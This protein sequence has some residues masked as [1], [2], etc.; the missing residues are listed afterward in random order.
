MNKVTPIILSGGIGSRLWPLSTKSK[1]KQFLKLP[2]NSKYNIFEQTLFGLKNP[3][4]FNKPLIICSEEHK[5]LILESLGKFKIPYSEIIVE[6]I[7]K[8]TATSVLLGVLYSMKKI[9]SETSLILPSDHFIPNRNYSKLIPKNLK[10]NK[11]HIIFGIKPEFPSTDYGYISIKNQKQRIS[12]V[13][14]FYEKPSKKRARD[15]IDKGFFWN[16]GIFL[17]NNETILSEFQKYIPNMFALC[18]QIVSKLKKDLDFLET[19][20]IKMK[21]LPNLSFDKAI[22]EKNNSLTMVKFCQP[23]R[24]LGSWNTLTEL[25]D[26][27]VKLDRKVKI[28]NNSKNSNVISDKK[29]T[30][31]NDIP[32]VVVVAK[33]DSLLISSKKNISKVKD[34]LKEKGNKDI[35]NSQN[36]FYRPWGHYETFIDS[37]NYLVKKLTIKPKHRLSLQF[38][39]FRSEHWVIVDGLAEIRKGKSKKTLKKNESTYIPKGVIHCIK[40]IGSSDLEIIEVQMGKIL[41]ESD[42]IRLDDPY[43]RT[44]K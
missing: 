29:N 44:K 4:K 42:I 2:F 28:I 12:E 6:K 40:N 25:S 26:K 24:D 22:L 30:I 38:H 20:H 35:C 27:N 17:L 43:K 39:K 18:S 23:W 10:N 36:L 14:K 41:K 21:K 1:P 34:I 15:F 31:L 5:F 16:T 37:P 7:S 13:T 32:N 33:K 11:R 9:K 8:N 19:D 3:K